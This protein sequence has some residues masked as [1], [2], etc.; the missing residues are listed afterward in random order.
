MIQS[1][2]E[3]R[4]FKRGK[5]ENKEGQ[6]RNTSIIFAKFHINNMKCKK[7]TNDF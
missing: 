1:N 4:I 2:D 6:I 7:I 3:I 5:L